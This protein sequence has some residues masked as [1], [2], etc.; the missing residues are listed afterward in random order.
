MKPVAVLGAAVVLSLMFGCA[1]VPPSTV[2]RDRFDYRQAIAESWKRQ[3]LMDVVRLR[4]ADAPVFLDI[5]SVIN[6]YTLSGSVGA[7]ASVK[8]AARPERV[9]SHRRRDLVQHPHSRLP[10]PHGGQTPEEPA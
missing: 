8:R 4:Y 5:S 3:T 2:T 7:T 6:S 1:H 10:A 9:R